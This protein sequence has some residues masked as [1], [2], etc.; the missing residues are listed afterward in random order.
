MTATQTCHSK[1]TVW[2]TKYNFIKK[3]K[4][5][6]MQFKW[7]GRQLTANKVTETI[8]QKWNDILQ[9]P[10]PTIVQ[11]S[12]TD[13]NIEAKVMPIYEQIQEEKKKKNWKEQKPNF[14]ASS[15]A[16]TFSKSGAIKHGTN[17][18]EYCLLWLSLH[19]GPCA[20]RPSSGVYTSHS[21]ANI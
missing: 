1:T 2:G 7:P 3:K 18:M 11:A 13:V 15:K 10:K 5:E 4:Y 14:G 9:Y 12:A 8:Q 17:K 16:W 6:M 21:T 20:H 19:F